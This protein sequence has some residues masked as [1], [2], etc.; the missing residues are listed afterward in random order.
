MR[1]DEI[2]QLTRRTVPNC[3]REKKRKKRSGC[4]GAVE[5]EEETHSPSQGIRFDESEDLWQS[6]GDQKKRSGR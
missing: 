5:V 1:L 4:T 6:T 3:R 2:T